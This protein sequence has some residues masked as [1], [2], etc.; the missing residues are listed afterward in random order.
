MKHKMTKSELIKKEQIAKAMKRKD[1]KKYMEK[2][3]GKRADEVRSRTAIKMA[4]KNESLEYYKGILYNMI[5]ENS[6]PPKDKSSIPQLDIANKDAMDRL[7]AQEKLEGIRPD[8]DPLTHIKNTGLNLSG[9]RAPGE[10]VS[11]SHGDIFDIAD[12]VRQA[13]FS[14][15]YGR[16]FQDGREVAKAAKTL[17]RY[18]IDHEK[19]ETPAGWK[20]SDHHKTDYGLT[21]MPG[22]I[23]RYKLEK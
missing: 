20:V 21:D 6:V 3:Y 11:V 8:V 12:G 4:Q 15:H 7:I 1:T 23:E 10:A 9:P 14:L 18:G 13:L 2:K 16:T 5:S 22:F 17:N 19:I